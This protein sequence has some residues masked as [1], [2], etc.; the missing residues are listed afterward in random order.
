[1]IARG[2]FDAAAAL[3][4]NIVQHAKDHPSM[5]PADRQARKTRPMKRQRP[6]IRR[7]AAV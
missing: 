5:W 2:T 4:A 1:L 7:A 3:K 6:G